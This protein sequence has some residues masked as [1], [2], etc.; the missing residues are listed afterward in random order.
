M[1]NT[2][3][4]P[5]PTPSAQPNSQLSSSAA[6]ADALS[7]LLHRLPPTLSLP[8]RRS[9]PSTSFPPIS[10]SDPNLQDLLFSASSQLGYFQ[11]TNHNIPSQLA[12]SAELES[13]SLLDLPKDKK[14][15]YFPKN[16]PL[17]FE[18]DEYGNGESFWLD[19][20]C[21]TV[22]TELVLSSLRQLTRALEKVGLEVIE[23]LSN[24]VGFENPLAEDPTRNCTLLWLHGALDGNDGLSGGSYPYI[25]GLQYQ[26][27]CQKYSLL[28]DSG[29]VTVL[30]QVDSIMVTVGEIAQ[31]WSNGRLKKVRGRPVACLGDCEN[32]S[33]IS[34]SLFVTLPSESTVSPLLPKV[35]TDGVN[36]EEDEIGEDEEQDNIDSVSKT[37]RRLF[38]S[39]SFED[40]AWRVYHEP[41]LFKDPLDKYRI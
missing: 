23:M 7:R 13:V 35:I 30:P 29:W 6:A 32:S 14:E 19:A 17:G 33:C 18:G 2:T 34:M 37:G 39:F 25:V 8:T 1:D 36:A 3:A 21:S 28:S 10:L 31:V 5:P 22:S 38:R 24:G 16:W 4:A 40:Y 9:K 11:L 27:R 41:L 20:E 12:T 26:I 15:S